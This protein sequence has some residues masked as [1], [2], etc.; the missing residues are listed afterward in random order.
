MEEKHYIISESTLFAFL[1]A[2][3]TLSML[4]ADGVD[5]WEWCGESRIETIQRF[6]PEDISEDEIRLKDITINDVATARIEAGE[7]NE[8]VNVEEIFDGILE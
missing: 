4:Y 8:L 1:T 6:Y 3:M 5:N 7:F 2:Q